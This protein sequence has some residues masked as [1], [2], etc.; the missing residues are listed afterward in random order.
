[1]PIRHGYSF[2]KTASTRRR[3]RMM[4]TNRQAVGSLHGGSRLTIQVNSCGQ[5]HNSR[6][7]GCGLGCPHRA[8]ACF[9][10]LSQFGRMALLNQIAV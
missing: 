2:W 8:M 7:S 1:M 4:I 5:T 3:R 6:L 10:N 9:L